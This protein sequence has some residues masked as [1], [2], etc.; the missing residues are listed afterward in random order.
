MTKIKICGISREPDVTYVNACLPEYVGFV[1]AESP[2]RVTAE[3]A[4][5][6]RKQLD[7][8]IQSVGVFVD[9]RPEIIEALCA[10]KIISLVQL[11]GNESEDYIRKLKRKVSV[12]LIKAFSP[13]LEDIQDTVANFLLLDGARAGSGEGFDRSL[14]GQPKLP[15]FLAGG[16]NPENVAEAVARTKPYAVDTSSGVESDGVKDFERIRAFIDAV[17]KETVR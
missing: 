11:H 15:F 8:R 7:T 2:R 17:R 12:P 16:L 13:S 14:I 10:D 5:S 3:T 6:L 4:L 1:F 9:E